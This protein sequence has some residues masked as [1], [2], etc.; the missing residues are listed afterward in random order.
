MFREVFT[1]I[2]FTKKKCNI[3]SSV[4]MQALAFYIHLVKLFLQLLIISE[5]I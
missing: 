4:I 1:E 2:K 5:H 3:K